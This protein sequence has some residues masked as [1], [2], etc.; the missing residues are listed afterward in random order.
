MTVITVAQPVE[1]PREIGLPRL[2]AFL[3]PPVA[4]SMAGFNG[5]QQVLIPGQVEALDPT[6]KVASLA[7]LT[8]CAA[9]TSM[10]GIPLGGALSDRTRSRFGKRTPWILGL[11]LLSGLLMIAMSLGDNLLTLGIVYA[12]LWLTANMHQGALVAILPD[13]VSG[14]RRGLASAIIGLGTPIGV[15]IG[16]NVASHIAPSSAYTMLALFLLAAS[17]MLALGAPEES[18]LEM[19]LPVA[20]S[21][22]KRGFSGFFEA[23]RE[24]DFTLAFVSRFALFLSYFTVSGYLFY[25]LSDYIGLDN[26]PQRN[27]PIA[28][29]TLLSISVII[30]V[31]VATFCG[32]LADRIDR[33]KLFVGISAVGLGATMLVPIISPTWTGMIVYSALSGAFIGTY[34]AVDLAV[35]SL[36]L[37]RQENAGRDLGLLA[38]ATGLPQIMSSVLAA[39]LITY[40]GGYIAL[41]VFGALCAVVA[42]SVALFIKK[43][44]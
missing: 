2:L 26:I 16:V 7:A 41:Y 8:M 36:V 13:R 6:S 17:A 18:S 5:I 30:W 39:G 31:F 20:E 21:G 33:R 24:R 43:V 14:Q 44:R 27:V 9:I 38:V 25:T 32:W 28:V 11:S 19:A 1:G 15:L 29:S 22:R 23:F 34:F 3:L 4:A 42:G 35:M 37:P 40:A 10:I 12:L